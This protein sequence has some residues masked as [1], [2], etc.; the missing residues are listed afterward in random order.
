MQSLKPNI[1]C[2]RIN[3]SLT[4]EHSMWERSNL[5]AF[6]R[7]R[8]VVSGRSLHKMDRVAGFTWL[9]E[10]LAHSLRCVCV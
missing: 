5:F 2:N 1:L 8:C 10:Q 3:L 9:C 4:K 6:R 7:T